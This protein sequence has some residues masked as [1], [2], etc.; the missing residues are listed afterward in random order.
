MVTTKLSL[1]FLI[2]NVEKKQLAN[3]NSESTF[4]SLIEGFNTDALY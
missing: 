4:L 2:L 1:P 3:V